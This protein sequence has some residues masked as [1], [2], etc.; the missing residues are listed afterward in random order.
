VDRLLAVQAQDLRSARIAVWARG[1][2]VTL[3]AIEQALARR[4]FVVGWLNRGT[5][6][7][8]RAADYWWLHELT[9]PQLFT[10]NERRLRQTGVDARAADRGVALIE[11]SLADGPLTRF[12][13]RDRLRVARIPTD[14][15]A[16]VH[17]LMRAC[18]LGVAVRGPLNGKTQAY[19]LAGD[20][21]PRRKPLDRDRALARLGQRYLAGHAPAD[22]RDLAKWAGITLADARRALGG[23]SELNGQTY[24]DE[25]RPCLLGQW[26]PVL[27]GWRD[28][29]ADYR[30]L[31]YAGGKVVLGW[32]ASGGRVTLDRP[33]RRFGAEAARLEA[34]LAG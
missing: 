13:L 5:L 31:G 25:A 14:G 22:D 2:D 20:W 9:T 24:D 34:F 1:R 19:V 30:P 33:L 16:V 15:Q 29:I 6:H 23:R 11:A 4:R 7:L 3:A 21:L 26:D 28:R 32:S 10:G 18:L 8:V 17:L 27:V 12:E